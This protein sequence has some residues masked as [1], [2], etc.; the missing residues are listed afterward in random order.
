MPDCPPASTPGH[1]NRKLRQL[2][3]LACAELEEGP[4]IQNKGLRKWAATVSSP[5]T[6]HFACGKC[7]RKGRWVPGVITPVGGPPIPKLCRKCGTDG[8]PG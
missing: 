3:T 7:G 6:V 2:L 8:S 5:K 1:E 4:G